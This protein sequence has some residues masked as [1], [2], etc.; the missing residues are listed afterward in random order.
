MSDD[1]AEIMGHKPAD[2]QNATLTPE[3]IELKWYKEVYQGDNMRQLTL[4]AVIMGGFLGGFMSLSNLYIGLKTGWGLGVAITACVLSY[5]I[6]KTLRTLLPF[7]F[8]SDMTI[9]EN[10]CMQSTASAAGYSTGGTMV[11]A[12]SAYLIITGSH[13]SWGVLTL[14]TIFLAALGVFIAIPM[15]R[16]M[17]N[18]EQLKFPSGI[19]AAETLKSLHS[20]GAE[21]ADKARA[22]AYGGTFGAL[23]SLL[24]D[25]G[26]SFNFKDLFGF[27]LS[28][29]GMLPFAG[30]IKGYPLEKWTFSFEVGA[31]MIAA[32]GIIGWKISWS[33]LLGAV[34]NYG[35]LAPWVSGMG[36]I[37]MEKLGYRAIVQWSTWGGAALMVTSGLFMFAL[38]WKTVMRAFGGITEIFQGRKS[39]A[40][41][42]PLAKI[43]VP[44]SWFLVGTAFSGLGCIMVLHYAFQ[45]SWWMGV[46]A[47][48]L[49]FFLAM[50]A[51]RATGE[52][53]ITPIGAMGKIT[54]LTF[55]ILAPSNMVTN[56]MTAS[57]TAGAAG[58]TADLLVDLKSGY[59]LGA[60][61]R[62]QF[63]AQFFGIF[64]GTLV[65]V[66]AFYI[67]VPDASALGSDQWPAP[68]AQVWAAVAKLLSNGVH[69]LHPAARM[70]M[71][72]GGLVGIII[73]LL[74]LAFP[75]KR[76][77]I[78]SAMGLGLAMVI[79]F[80][81]SLSMFLGGLIA[82]IIEKKNKDVAEKYIIPV[83]SGIIAGESLMGVAIA[84]SDARGMF[85]AFLAPVKPFLAAVKAFVRLP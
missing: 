64:A 6:W 48:I 85:T 27:K 69:S 33:L 46:I 74:E 15:K 47:V 10:N 56:L 1:K 75:K 4:R 39:G 2:Q 63:L 54:Q 8:K 58:S 78:P 17:I 50:V 14:W 25:K 80:W 22:L 41:E 7:L 9:L 59:L 26:V 57:V 12:I 81:N 35:I 62:Q 29:P 16:Q 82:L 18:I 70:G 68:S 42:D 73:P 83:S 13:M 23:V 24:R 32:G 19:A 40:V 72:V 11:S 84:L 44:G 5:T 45:T 53:D 61:P 20:K 67:L 60:N 36:A 51:A 71:L 3:E 21:A 55:G 30:H 79:P 66:P 52:S 37:G 76:K 49:T 34:I 65:V 77:Y 31:L 38:Q 43:E 28:L